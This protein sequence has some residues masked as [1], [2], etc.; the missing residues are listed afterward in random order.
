MGRELGTHAATLNRRLLP[1]VPQPC[2]GWLLSQV[3]LSGIYCLFSITRQ[4]NCHTDVGIVTHSVSPWGSPPLCPGTMGAA[5]RE[6]HGGDAKVAPGR[7][8]ADVLFVGLLLEGLACPCT[9]VS[10]R[11][12]PE[13]SRQEGRI[14]CLLWALSVLFLFS[15]MAF[16]A[17]GNDPW[18]SFIS[19]LLSGGLCRQHNARPARH[20]TRASPC[21][22]YSHK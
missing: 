19:L 12:G 22:R 3:S 13:R 18:P 8:R 4:R 21:Y 10:R 9:P 17:Q 1:R 16:V 7:G 5:F 2:H 20:S 6:G 15:R 14:F 11:Q